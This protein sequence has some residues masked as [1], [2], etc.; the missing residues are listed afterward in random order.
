MGRGQG[1]PVACYP[2]RSHQRVAILCPLA[3]ALGARL[4]EHPILLAGA[5]IGMGDEVAT[6]CLGTCLES[7]TPLVVGLGEVQQKA[8]TVPADHTGA[9]DE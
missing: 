5:A 6:R 2:S 8:S 3:E 9:L 4:G 7:V 1:A